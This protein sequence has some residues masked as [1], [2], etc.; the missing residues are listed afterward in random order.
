MPGTPSASA[1]SGRGCSRRR[2][3]RRRLHEGRKVG[4]KA[5]PSGL[6]RVGGEGHASPLRRR[7]WA[8]PSSSGASPRGATLSSA[9]ADALRD[10]PPALR[11]VGLVEHLDR[12][13]ADQNL[14]EHVFVVAIR[15]RAAFDIAAAGAQDPAPGRDLPAHSSGISER[16]AS[17]RP[18]VLAALGVMR[19]AGQHRVRPVRGA[20]GVG[21]VK[22]APAAMPNR[23]G[24][25]PTSFSATNRLIAIEGRVLD[26]LGH[27]RPGVLLQPHGEAQRRCAAQ[28]PCAAQ[29]P[30]RSPSARSRGSR[31]RTAWRSGSIR[32]ARVDRPVEVAPVGFGRAFPEVD[33]GAVDREVGD[34]LAGSRAPGGCG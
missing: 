19:R 11:S 10:R 9:C 27:H 26:A 13:G 8:R 31:T 16:T 22:G 18:R 7:R 24:A 15:R 32:R 29:P 12:P 20:L 4:E 3:A 34:D 2:A 25:P 30:R 1:R 17:L 14:V 21:L 6:Q 33:I 5:R 28:A 23:S